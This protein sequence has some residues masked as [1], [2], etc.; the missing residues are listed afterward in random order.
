MDEEADDQF[1]LPRPRRWTSLQLQHSLHPHLRRQRYL[2]NSANSPSTAQ[3][4]HQPT[5]GL[6][7]GNTLIYHQ[8]IS[9]RDVQLNHAWRSDWQLQKIAE[10]DEAYLAK[11][12]D[13]TIATKEV[14]RTEVRENRKKHVSEIASMRRF[15]AKANRRSPLPPSTRKRNLSPDHSGPIDLTS[16]HPAISMTALSSDSEPPRALKR[17]RQQPHAQASPS[18]APP[19]SPERTEYRSHRRSNAHAS[20]HLR[21]VSPQV[22]DSLPSTASIPHDPDAV[23]YMELCNSRH[24]SI[25]MSSSEQPPSNA[26][27]PSPLTAAQPRQD[28]HPG[29]AS[30]L[31]PSLTPLVFR[32]PPSDPMSPLDLPPAIALRSPSSGSSPPSSVSFPTLSQLQRIA[33]SHPESLESNDIIPAT[34]YDDPTA[35]FTT[36]LPG[37][38]QLRASISETALSRS[39]LEKFFSSP[40]HL[41]VKDC[42]ALRSTALWDAGLHSSPRH[43]PRSSLSLPRPSP[44][45]S[46]DET[47]FLQYRLNEHS[48]SGS[49]IFPSPDMATYDRPE[50]TGS[51]NSLAKS[52]SCQYPSPAP[53]TLATSLFPGQHR[54]HTLPEPR[55]SSILSPSIP[56]PTSPLPLMTSITRPS[57]PDTSH[58]PHSRSIG[59]LVARYLS[60]YPYRANSCGSIGSIQ[61]VDDESLFRHPLDLPPPTFGTPPSCPPESFFGSPPRP[62][63]PDVRPESCSA[64]TPHHSLS[65]NPLQQ[66]NP[67]VSDLVIPPSLLSQ[68]IATP[69]QLSGGP[70]QDEHHRGRPDS[71]PLPAQQESDY[72]PSSDE[73]LFTIIA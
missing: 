26:Q 41:P 50:A 57:A 53:H 28:D 65:S 46:L 60:L 73:V 6:N 35:G 2:V 18:S 59:P 70:G 20:T 45:F 4:S 24:D 43:R 7:Q 62:Q 27:S 66:G 54:D 33:E 3:S 68:L 32:F 52:S 71:P 23:N 22:Q 72:L 47:E 63:S 48:P 29:H 19:S 5:L 42:D 21:P 61:V 55:C 64:N 12:S 10:S 67:A 30:S 31:S 11:K 9:T 17:R 37:S 39:H 34:D 38:S 13:L 8:V 49:A 1:P 58:H 14:E 56:S 69:S 44:R 40:P 51:Q 36:S 16:C 15:L 25:R